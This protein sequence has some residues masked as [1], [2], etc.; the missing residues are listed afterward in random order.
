M[1]RVQNVILTV[2]KIPMLFSG[3]NT[4]AFTNIMAL[5]IILH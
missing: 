2:M 4:V 3:K 1:L 5:P